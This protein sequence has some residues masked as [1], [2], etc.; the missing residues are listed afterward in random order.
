MNMLTPTEAARLILE[1][2]APL[3]EVRRPLHEALDLVLAEDVVSPM[4]LPPWDNSAMDGY[5]A[6]AVDVAGASAE[7]KVVLAQVESVAAGQFPERPIGPG[8]ATRIFTGAPLPAG[9]D[10]VVRQEDTEDAGPE[11]VTVV[12]GRDAG[13]NVRHRGED[14]RKGEVVLAD[15]TPLGPAQLGVLASVAH[16]TPLVHRAPRVA[17]MGSGDEIVD[18]DRADEI[19]AGRKIATSN[20]YTLHALIR[21]AGGIPVDLG[22]ARDTKD[23]LREHL[24]GARDA[25]LLVTTAGVSVGEHD[26]VRDV[27]AEL[28][29]DMKLWRIRMRPGAPLGFGL[30]G[31]TP[32]IGLPGNP[33]STMVTFEL[34]VR[35]AIRRL[36]GHRLPFRRT[37]PVCVGEPVT[38]GPRLRHF[39]RAVVQPEGRGGGLVARLTGPQGSGILTSMARANALLIVPE[40]RSEVSAGETLTAL[41][42]DDPH[43]VAEAPF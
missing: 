38:L 27:L 35:P 40:D 11:R 28:G 43:H 42:L 9:A 37:V 19:L 22:L 2:V 41:L 31:P 18:L 39:L 5:A 1:H 32:W 20:S 16:G 15:G 4:D 14:I 21:R 12:A 10:T 34:F 7:R 25:D 29:C 36:L 3:P 6:R 24:G 30:L 8:Q 26:F 33:V 23:S 13:K 17:F